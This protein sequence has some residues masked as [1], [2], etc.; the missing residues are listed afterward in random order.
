MKKRFILTSMFLSAVVLIYGQ[1]S[2]PTDYKGGNSI[3]LQ[4]DAFDFMAKGF[5]IWCNYTSNYNRIF[6][7]VGRN[8]L[9]DFLNPLSDDFVEKRKYFIQT[10]Y[11]RFLDKPD[12]FFVGVELI[13]QRMELNIMIF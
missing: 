4:M 9:P 5:S 2:I 11:Y 7:D 13:F 6:L 12:G 1:R 10:G 8:E 3:G